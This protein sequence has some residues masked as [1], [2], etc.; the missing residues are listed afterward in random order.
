MTPEQ[1]DKFIKQSWLKEF[2]DDSHVS[3]YCYTLAFKAG[4][5]VGYDTGYK[6][7]G[8]I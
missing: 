1:L 7:G 4:Y 5:D 2:G 3:L 6:D 8:Y